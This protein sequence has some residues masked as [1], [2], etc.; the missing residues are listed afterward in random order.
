MLNQKKKISAIFAKH[1]NSN[2]Y[3]E[4]VYIDN[5]KEYK[6]DDEIFADIDESIKNICIQSDNTQ[7]DNKKKTE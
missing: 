7:E 4:L 3:D 2:L 6:N 5:N 1:A